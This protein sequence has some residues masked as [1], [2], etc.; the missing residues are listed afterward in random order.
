M[1]ICEYGDINEIQT[2]L[3]NKF[4]YIKTIIILIMKIQVSLK[5][6]EKCGLF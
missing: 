2:L 3:V 1:L 6:K 4:R 5:E